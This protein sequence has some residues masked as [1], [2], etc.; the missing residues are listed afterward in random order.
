MSPHGVPRYLAYLG[1]GHNGQAGVVPLLGC[2][3]WELMKPSAEMRILPLL[4]WRYLVLTFRQHDVGG[5]I[6]IRYL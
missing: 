2:L 1:A 4:L 5:I 6:T 3:V